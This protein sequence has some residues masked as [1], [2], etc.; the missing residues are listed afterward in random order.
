MLEPAYDTQEATQ[1]HLVPRLL[2]LW[3]TEIVKDVGNHQ[4]IRS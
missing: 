1:T 3:E 4:I 2:D